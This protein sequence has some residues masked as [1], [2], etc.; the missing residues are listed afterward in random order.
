[1]E[2]VAG[3]CYDCVKGQDEM[4][5]WTWDFLR[6]IGVEGNRVVCV[7]C[8]CCLCREKSFC[9]I[10]LFEFVNIYSKKNC[11]EFVKKFFRLHITFVCNNYHRKQPCFQISNSFEMFIQIMNCVHS[12]HLF[13][14]LF[15]FI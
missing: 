2:T 3:I 6:S 13:L 14:V 7:W 5:T 12:I 8:R 4:A 11:L 1:M 9:G 15:V 10:H